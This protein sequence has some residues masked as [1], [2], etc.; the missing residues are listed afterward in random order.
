[1]KVLVT[2]G[3]G[4]IGSHTAKALAAAGHEPVVLDNL[5]RGHRWAV[6]YGPFVE[7]DIRDE[8][9]VRTAL[10]E[11]KI[12]SII[13]FAALA[14]VGES[15]EQPGLY[16]SNNVEGLRSVLD[17]AMKEGV[18]NIVFSSS[19]ATYGDP[20]RVPVDEECRQRPVSPYGDTKLVGEH[21]LKWFEMSGPI[22]SVALRYFNASG[23]DPD[24]EIGEDHD[25]E[26]HLIPSAMLAAQGRR[27]PLELYGTDYPTRDGTAE[28]DYIHVSDLAAAH[29]LAVG[30]LAGGGKSTALNLGSEKGATVREVLQ[31]VEEVSARKVP[32][33]ERPRRA[34]DAIALRASAKLAHET[35]GWKPVMSDLR[36]ICETAWN[37]YSHAR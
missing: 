32:Y 27:G 9:A 14:Y 29:V 37:W 15:V 19:C 20:E 18:A 16:F 21:L 3:A 6:K 13:H 31:A 24:G 33:V 23:C 26:T 7:A 11:H 12:E 28:R 8:L 10:R 36:T 30:Y 1:M 35:L 34:G 2:G 5:F 22:G 17:A 25:P 4:Y